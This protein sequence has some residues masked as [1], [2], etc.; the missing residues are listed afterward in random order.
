MNN[1]YDYL[2][3]ILMIGDSSVGKS[4]IL[5]QYIDNTFTDSHIATIGVDF[6]ITTV[7]IE[8]HTA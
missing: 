6:K 4:S 5:S 8:E 3:K 2:F 7:I 1:N